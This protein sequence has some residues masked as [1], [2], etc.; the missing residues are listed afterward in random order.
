MWVA[1]ALVL[2]PATHPAFAQTEPEPLLPLG[3]RIRIWAP[4]HDLKKRR[5]DL[6]AWGHT[7]LTVAD[8]VYRGELPF[9][10]VRRLDVSEGVGTSGSDVLKGAGIGFVLGGVAGTIVGLAAVSG[11]EEFLC[12]MEWASYMAVGALGGSA[13]G[14]G[15]GAMPREQ[16]KS[17]HLPPEMGFPE[18]KKPLHKSFLFNAILAGATLAVLLATQ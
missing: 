14:A 2:L 13:I 15:V 18:Q 5:L 16:W 4:D 17:V 12:E 6:I 9:S 8:T 10:G 1:L 3:S 11:C 7:S